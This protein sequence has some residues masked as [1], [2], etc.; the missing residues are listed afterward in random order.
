M[1][2]AHP[3]IIRSVFGR[4]FQASMV[5]WL[6]S[7]CFIRLLVWL[8]DWLLILIDFDCI[9]FGFYNLRSGDSWILGFKANS[10]KKSQED[11]VLSAGSVESVLVGHLQTARSSAKLSSAL[12]SDFPSLR[13]QKQVIN[14]A[15]LVINAVCSMY[16]MYQDSM[17]G[18]QEALKKIQSTSGDLRCVLFQWGIPC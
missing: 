8:H 1:L 14:D 7:W 3:L 12:P 5:S 16:S 10:W 15:H 13:L 4:F 11:A 9:R 18:W 6:V 17:I 2:P